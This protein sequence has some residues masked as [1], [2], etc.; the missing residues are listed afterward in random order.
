MKTSLALSEKNYNI[1][2]KF[3]TRPKLAIVGLFVIVVLLILLPIASSMWLEQTRT[4]LRQERTQTIIT[5]AQVVDLFSTLQD[6][7]TGQRGYIITGN[8]VFLDPYNDGLKHLQQILPDLRNSI[9]SDPTTSGLMIPLDRLIELKKEEMA[10]AIK[11]RKTSGFEINRF[12]VT[13]QEGKIY[14]DQIR[15]IINEL[16]N[17]EQ[18]RTDALFK[19]LISRSR[20]SFFVGVASF[21]FCVT[22]LS[23]LTACVLRL[24]DLRTK[25]FDERTKL[26][27]KVSNLAYFDPLTGLANR[28]TFEENTDKILKQPIIDGHPTTMFLVDL[29]N[30]K[31]IN[32]SY[33]HLIGDNVLQIIAKRLEF[34]VNQATK[35]HNT[36]GFVA[37]L[38][39]DEFII[40][41]EHLTHGE[42]KIVGTLITQKVK[43]EIEIDNIIINCSTS[44]GISIFGADNGTTTYSLFKCA[45]VAMYTS[46]EKGRDQFT[47]YENSMNTKL[48]RRVAAEQLIRTIIQSEEF[49]LFF[50]PI[51]DVNTDK[52]ISC[53][54]LLRP[55]KGTED[56][57]FSPMEIVEVAEE[58]RLIIPLGLIILRKACEFGKI[59]LDRGI[60]ID[61]AVN[62]SASQ[63]M[64]PNFKINVK[65]VLDKTRF[66]SK[67]LIIE[68][69]ETLLISNFDTS[70]AVLVEL[71][72]LGINISIDDFGKGYS[73]FNYL[74]TLPINKLKIDMSFIQKLGNDNKSDE[75][76]K[77]IILMA[78]ALGI[79]TC[80]EGVE[81]ETQYTK[82]KSFGCDQIQGYYMYFAMKP[83]QF[84]EVIKDK[85]G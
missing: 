84:F 78:D 11:T 42:T 64:D 2:V 53:E 21:V 35:F 83:S 36:N 37:R 73:S 22:L 39:G 16:H 69:T 5:T 19:E 25:L 14:M 23:I 27:E 74:N 68:I 28:L 77:A 66:P 17:I 40:V 6:L 45:D 24:V 38:G 4:H 67:N 48:Q 55:P 56:E 13:S 15:I 50:Q 8:K 41:F 43:E 54:A 32:D 79:T 46:K 72:E 12:I 82:L 70:L 18:G 3:I 47:F 20:L 1:I 52:V 31:N 51:V 59:C 76:V 61:V 58:T 71:C 60:N 49:E 34:V 75:I 63:L 30:F 62:V 29:D 9:H 33:G 26:F 65:Q 10:S 57:I 80:A 81:T 44:I 85:F 7:E